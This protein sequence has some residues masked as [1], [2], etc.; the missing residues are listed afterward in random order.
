MTI[1]P[2]NVAATVSAA[3]VTKT[4]KMRPQSFCTLSEASGEI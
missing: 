4:T 2:V 3:S 1:A